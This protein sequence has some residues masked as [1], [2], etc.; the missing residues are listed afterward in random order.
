MYIFTVPKNSIGNKFLNTLK[1]IPN[2][3]I[4]IKGHNCDAIG[5]KSFMSSISARALR[6]CPA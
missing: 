4:C 6:A 5:V 3:K 2:Y 1:T